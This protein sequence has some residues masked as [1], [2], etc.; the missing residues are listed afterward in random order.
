MIR[1]GVVEHHGYV[2]VLPGA[3]LSPRK[4]LNYALQTAD[5][6]RRYDMED[7]HRV[8]VISGWRSASTMTPPPPTR[9]SAHP[10]LPPAGG[11]RRPFV[12]RPPHRRGGNGR[13]RNN[14]PGPRATPVEGGGGGP[15]RPRPRWPPQQ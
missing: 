14:G 10:A 3:R 6:R 9:G 11:P 15:R 7:A 13:G 8:L 4:Q 12:P 2:D 5:V 1:V